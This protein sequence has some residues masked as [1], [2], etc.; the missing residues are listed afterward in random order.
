[1][2]WVGTRRPRPPDDPGRLPRL[3]LGSV[4]AGSFVITLAALAVLTWAALTLLH[5]PKLSQQKTISVH[6]AI[7]VAQLVFASVAGAG[8]LVALVVAYRRQRVTEANSA[9][10]RERWQVA[11]AHDRARVLNERFTATAA[12]LG[13]QN[14][15]VRLAGVHAM[16]GLADDW[17]E[18]RQTCI[19]VLC[20]Y[21]RIPY[22]PE[23]GDDAPAAGRL[24]FRGNREVRH[25]VIRVI[26]AHLRKD[27]RVS[28][29][30]RDLDFTGVVFDGGDF[31]GALFSG[32]EVGFGSAQFSGGT[33]YFTRTQ[34]SG[35]NVYF[36]DAQFSGGKV[37][38][39]DA[40]FSGGQVNFID[41]ELSGGEVSFGDVKFSA[42]TVYFG[43]AQFSGGNVY[44]G[45]AQF[46]GG[47][48]D[49]VGAQFSGC[50]VYFSG[51]EFSGSTVYLG[52]VKFSGGEI[53]RASCRERV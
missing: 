42:G 31:S 14:T 5:H 24:S 23:P 52:D 44:F 35:G 10:D 12:Q 26:T 32:G 50:K 43:S 37:Y 39:G 38:F 6:D 36:G 16:A 1:M 25:T 15:A 18:N 13:D 49:F 28:W 53:G 45:N 33:V 47:K 21:L 20:A 40:Q 3:R 19:D 8:A 27:A 48:A 41:A 34:F 51:T 30:G 22:E 4:L 7:G 29:Q 2:E 9:H 46:S 11:S 17:T